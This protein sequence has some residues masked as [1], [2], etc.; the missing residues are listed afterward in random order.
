MRARSCCGRLR[1]RSSRRRRLPRGL[2][3]DH[4]ALRWA[5]PGVHGVRVQHRRRGRM[6]A[7][8]SS[9]PERPVRR[10]RHERHRRGRHV[11]QYHDEHARLWRRVSNRHTGQ[12]HAERGR[13]HAARAPY[14]VPPGRTERGRVRRWQGVRAQGR[15]IAWSCVC[16]S[17]RPRGA[18]PPRL[19]PR[20]RFLRASRRR[21]AVHMQLQ[22][23]LRSKLRRY[24]EALTL[25]R[26]RM[27]GRA[28]A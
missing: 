13:E 2:A 22:R 6:S 19:R 9:L 1:S 16:A 7:L 27:R 14:G 26:R 17:G 12:L 15:G 8:G 25:R 23:C 10:A 5:R 4:V 28:G 20:G 11:R 24:R 21:P 3:L 18:L